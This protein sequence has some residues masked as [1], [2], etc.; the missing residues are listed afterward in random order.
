M[1]Q[2][3]SFLWTR[4]N[5]RYRLALRARHGI[6][7]LCSSKLILKEALVSLSQPVYWLRV[8]L[9]YELCLLLA[10]TVLFGLDSVNAELLDC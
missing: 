9:E 6:G 2:I 3:Y 4:K 8:P 10:E 1:G 5:P 7:T